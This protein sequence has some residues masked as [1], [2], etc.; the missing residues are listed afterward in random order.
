MS[1]IKK[2]IAVI[3]EANLK[4]IEGTDKYRL[5]LSVSLYDNQRPHLLNYET[6]KLENLQRRFDFSEADPKTNRVKSIEQRK[7]IINDD[8]NVYSF[9]SFI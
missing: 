4:K 2:H 9:A 3:E 5:M 7:C 1:K 8:N 6:D